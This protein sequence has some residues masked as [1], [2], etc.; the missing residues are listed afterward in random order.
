[1]EERLR[2]GEEI[3]T[4]SEL[5]GWPDAIIMDDED[6]EKYDLVLKIIIPEKYNLAFS[7]YGYKM[8]V[9]RI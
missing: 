6:C 8:Y 5:T 3:E 1:M 9:K 4:F 2:A 7:S